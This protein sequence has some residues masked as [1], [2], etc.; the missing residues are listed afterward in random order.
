MPPISSIS[1]LLTRRRHI[2]HKWETFSSNFIFLRQATGE[3]L[4][5]YSVSCCPMSDLFDKGKSILDEAGG[6]N[7]VFS[8]DA[9]YQKL[10]SLCCSS[11]S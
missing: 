5:S 8:S 10:Y 4:Y 7:R 11:Q 2:K 6:L 1:E 3:I 9:I